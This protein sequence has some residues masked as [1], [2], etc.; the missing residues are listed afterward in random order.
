MPLLDKNLKLLQNY[1][2]EEHLNCIKYDVKNPFYL[3][4][5]YSKKWEKNCNLIPYNI[6]TYLL[7]AYYNLPERPDIAFLFFWECINNLYNDE[8]FNIDRNKDYSDSQGIQIISELLNT[9]IKKSYQ[10]LGNN[11]NLQNIFVQLLNQCPIKAYHFISSYILKGYAIEQKLAGCKKKDLNQT[12]SSFKKKC[13]F[14]TKI[15]N[16][17]GNAYKNL[18]TPIRTGNGVKLNISDKDKSRRIIHSLSVKLKELIENGNTQFT[19]T[20]NSIETVILEPEKRIPFLIRHLLY[21]IRCNSFHGNVAS[22]LNSI[23]ANQDS[24]DVSKFICILSYFFI[25]LLLI[26]KSQMDE[27]DF[28]CSLNL[29]KHNYNI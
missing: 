12:Y 2:K 6:S 22:R 24:Y 10:I 8:Q 7:D 1:T 4:P 28:N 25:N 23:Y 11:I 21:A 15:E 17:Y 29:L 20:D 26:Q 18:C 19:L 3:V 5:L 13:P 14:I 9:E 27:E 16:S